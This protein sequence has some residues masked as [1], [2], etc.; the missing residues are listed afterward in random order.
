MS[1]IITLTTDWGWRDFFVG[2][3]KGK[4]LSMLPDARIVDITHEIDSFN[5]KSA[6]FVARNACLDYPEGTI[7]IIDVNSTDTA[8]TPTVVV[9]CK[10]QYY[11]CT[12]NG[13]PGTL[14]SG[15]DYEA[16]VVDKV[17]W[18]SSFYTFA[19]YDYFCKVVVMLS[20]GAS[21]EDIGY[22]A[23]ELLSLKPWNMVVKDDVAYVY[24]AYFDTYGNADLAI[25]Y[26]EFEKLRAGRKFTMKV[27]EQE[28]TQVS[29]G[30]AERL[31][32]SSSKSKLMLTVSSS[33]YLQLAIYGQSVEQL[34]G[35]NVD[36]RIDIKFK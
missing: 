25:T 5:L 13:L 32:D 2:K 3:F 7:H 8:Q 11:I 12:D 16:V 23:D 24:V 22:K 36:D 27:R 31:V 14:F 1:P 6:Y 34:F 29:K 30:Y 4:L 20:Q 19:A 35:L 15:L 17:Y 10:G 9:K 18:D 28:L 33:G 26:E 21:L